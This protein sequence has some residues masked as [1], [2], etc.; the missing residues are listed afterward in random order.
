M[1]TKQI[2]E[3]LTDLQQGLAQ[4]DL[5]ETET[6]KGQ[7]REAIALMN[8]LS[9]TNIGPILES[10]K[11]DQI[12]SSIRKTASLERLFETVVLEIQ[13]V[14]D[15]SRAVVYQFDQ[16]S[17][18]VLAEA[19]TRG[20]TPMRSENIPLESFGLEKYNREAAYYYKQISN[21]DQASLTP[22]Q[23]QL[24][25]KYQVKA[26]TCVPIIHENSVWGLLVIQQCGSDRTWSNDE[27]ALLDAIAQEVAVQLQIANVRQQLGTKVA[28]DKLVSQITNKI[29]GSKDLDNIFNY[30][31]NALR[32]FLNCDRVAIYRFDENWNGEFIHESRGN[33]WVDLIE[34][35]RHNRALLNNIDNC[36]VWDL[37]S[38]SRSVVSGDT[39]I[40]Q[41][42]G[43]I[44]EHSKLYRVTSDIYIEGFPDCYIEVLESYQARAYV[45]AA[46]YCNG[47]LWGLMPVYQ[48]SGA[49]QW[50]QDE[51]DLVLDVAKQLKIAVQQAQYRQ[52]VAEVQGQLEQKVREEKLI[53]QISSKILESTDLSNIF[54]YSCQTLRKFLK[55]DR[56]GIY[57]FEENWQGK[58]IIESRGT[59]W[60]SLLEE[61]ERNPAVVK[62]VSN[63]SVQDLVHGARPGKNAEH[64]QIYRVCHDLYNSNLDDAF[65]QI[66][67][68]YQAKAY[69]VAAIYC[70]DKLWG[71]LT[72]YQNS[73]TRQWK[74]AEIELILDV[75][76]QL[77]IAIQ[78]DLA[79]KQIEQNTLD[80][81]LK[82]RR[83]K[84]LQ[85]IV[86]QIR[87]NDAT[88]LIFDNTCREL[89]QFLNSDRVAILEFSPEDDYAKGVCLAEDVLSQYPSVLEAEVE[90][91]CFAEKYADREEFWVSTIEDSQTANIKP[92]YLSILERFAIRA[93]LVAPLFIGK[94][95]WGVIAVHQCGRPR[96]WTKDEIEFV[97]QVSTQL[98]VALQQR[99]YIQQVQSQLQR[100][101]TI[102]TIVTQTRQNID[103]QLIFNSTCREV[104]HF[105]DAD[106]VAIYQFDTST[107]Y[108]YGEFVAEDVLPQYAPALGVRVKDHCFVQ[109]YANQDKMWASIIEDIATCGRQECH[110]AMLAKFETQAHI[111]VPLFIGKTLWGL[112]CIYQCGAPRKWGH[113]EIEFAKQ[114]SAQLGIALQQRQYINTVEQQL[115]QEKALARAVDVI[116]QSQDQK[117][118]FRNVLPLFRETLTCDRIAVYQFNSDWGGEFVAESVDNKWVSLVGPDTKTVWEDEY[119]R[120]TQGGR[121]RNNETLAIVDLQK[122]GFQQCHLDIL[123]QFQAK[124][125]VIAPIFA[126]AELWGLLGVYQNDRIRNWNN[127]EIQLVTR[128]GSQLGVGIKQSQYLEQVQISTQELEKALDREKHAKEQLQ[129]EALEMLRAVQPSFQGDLTVRAPFSPGELGTIADGYNTT[130]TNLRELVKQVKDTALKVGET[131]DQSNFSVNQL[132]AQA[133]KQSQ[134][135]KEALQQ[136][137]VMVLATEAVTSNA[138]KVE[139]AVQQANR[140][141]NA[142]D[143]IMERTVDE[144]LEIRETVSQTAKKIKRLGESS[145][146]ISKVVHL[147]ENFATQTNLLALNAAIE[148]TRAGEYGK[149]FAV[150]ADEVRSLAYQSANA[151][152]EIER[153]VQ[154]IQKEINEVTEAMEIGISQVV[155][156]S[157]LVDETRNSLSAI[158]VATN[159]ISSLFAGITETAHNQSQQSQSLTSAM[160]EVAQVAQKTRE[161]SCQISESFRKLLTTSQS[162]QTSV[163][164]FKID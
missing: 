85:S 26:S 82:A 23:L 79:R 114:I 56:I 160:T 76:K 95:F 109:T 139:Q 68:T 30:T 11:L 58:F 111:I 117:S 96:K 38:R 9:L 42:Q 125:Y 93:N 62:S 69:V 119:L 163:S 61:Q 3:T 1:T 18:M 6:L 74:P 99:Q 121:Y 153:F 113:E 45:I 149:G 39:H 154:D 128:L 64:S 156:G 63:C 81:K 129:E 141:V 22:Y 73:D 108:N 102:Q 19:L 151:T 90:D 44:F 29:L 122:A 115:A 32:K 66:L 12:V 48:N 91:N 52:Q 8:D 80:L 71:V 84:T 37:T 140:T 145:Q 94:Q 152:T 24:M 132:A 59:E 161:S 103:V 138:Q 20:F 148:A 10:P 97:K 110:K 27:L 78:Q 105:L 126:G 146:K 164:Q 35:Q 131:S 86:S 120:K 46:I 25:T 77:K 124:A 40:R 13:K 17:G 4:T 130:I 136:L 2:L 5:V 135:M 137:Q 7:I 144:M 16:Q 158:V 67:E 34:E 150:V 47:E 15:V 100:E 54:D 36:A 98:G 92:C 89:R 31:C 21:D 112:F 60:I 28:G 65:I 43:Q 88:Q 49:R 57:Q 159:E 116:R 50:M 70:E 147:I 143:S 83:E 107:E 162:L 33:G 134:Q 55:C 53:S 133:Q 123:E 142:G 75:S 106:R 72:V 127:S 155:K 118:I 14:L 87:Q 51:I 41:H 104:R 101:K 157:D